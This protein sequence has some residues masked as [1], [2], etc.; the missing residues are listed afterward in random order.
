MFRV[1]YPK[2][3]S[4][5]ETYKEVIRIAWPA[6]TE[7]ILVQLCTL[8]DQM[9]V[10]KLGS[11]A[12]ASVAFCTQPRFL[13]LCT[14]IALNTGATALVARFKGSEERNLANIAVGQCL[15]LSVLLSLILSVI[16]FCFSREMVIFMGAETPKV[17]EDATVYMKIQMLGFVF[18]AIAMSVTASLRGIGKTKISMYYNLIANVINVICNYLLIYGKFGLPRLEV[19]GASLATVIGQ[20]VACVISLIVILNKKNYIYLTLNSLKINFSMWKRIINIGLP[21]ML[22]Q[23]VLRFGLIIYTLTVTSLGETVYATH[24]ICLNIMSLSF[25][26]GQAFGVSATSLLGQSLGKNR[27]D[28]A[29]AYTHGCRKLG[30][31]VSLLLSVCLCVFSRELI[32][33]FTEEQ[34]IIDLGSSIMFV[35]AVNQPLQASQLII[36]GALRGAG[37]TRLVAI[38]T[39][40]GM[41]LIRPF[42][43]M[44]M[45]KVLNL[46]LMGAW[47]AVILDQIIRSLIVFIRFANGKWEKIKV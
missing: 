36:S 23:F 21:A 47:L 34:F 26:N 28:M 39:F 46:G 5:K 12:L 11:D 32:S 30:L 14:F 16:G 2:D 7:L 20:V 41:F 33:L 3:L 6:L 10:G 13:L 8:V 4:K 31:Y 24:Q 42:T 43:S 19:A 1:E 37:D 25:M 27:P 18:N 44:F 40:I 29:R 35:L 38:S 45:V 22:E 15:V 17:I 9:M